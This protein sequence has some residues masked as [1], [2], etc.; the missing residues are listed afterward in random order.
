ML[1]VF[2]FVFGGHDVVLDSQCKDFVGIV[3]GI[4]IIDD[5]V[6]KTGNAHVYTI[7]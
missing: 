2:I 5:K 3:L 7:K 4:G 1:L 6:G